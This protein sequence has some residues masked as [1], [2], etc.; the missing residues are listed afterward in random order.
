MVVTEDT[1]KIND[2]WLDLKGSSF[3]P[4]C[5]TLLSRATAWHTV[6]GQ[7]KPVRALAGDQSDLFRIFQI[8]AWILLYKLLQFG[9]NRCL[10]F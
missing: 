4:L 7:M 5:A 1:F 6:R 10:I 9:L 8:T 3:K 2:A